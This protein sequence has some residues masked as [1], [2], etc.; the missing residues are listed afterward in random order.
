[1][2]QILLVLGVFEKLFDEE[3]GSIHPS[4]GLVP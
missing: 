3:E 4:V 2:L 1:M